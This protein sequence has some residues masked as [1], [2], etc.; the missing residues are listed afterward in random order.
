MYLAHGDNRNAHAAQC[1]NMQW[2][3]GLTQDSNLKAHG[4]WHVVSQSMLRE[5]DIT[6]DQFS[7]YTVN[8]A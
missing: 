2:K 4:E 3:V 6:I 7:S 8:T 5:Y 1:R